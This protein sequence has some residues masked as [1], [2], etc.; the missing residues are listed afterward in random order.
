MRMIFRVMTAPNIM[1]ITVMMIML[2]LFPVLDK[3]PGDLPPASSRS[4]L[5]WA[6]AVVRTWGYQATT[7]VRYCLARAI[8]IV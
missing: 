6:P 2:L 3:Q 5:R 8:V 7:V 4:S 1:I